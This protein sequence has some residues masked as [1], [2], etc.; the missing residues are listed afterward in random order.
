MIKSLRN[1][2]KWFSLDRMFHFHK[3]YGGLKSCTNTKIF[4]IGLVSIY[5]QT[6]LV[7]VNQG[8]LAW[9]FRQFWLELVVKINEDNNTTYGKWSC[10]KFLLWVKV[11]ASCDSAITMFFVKLHTFTCKNAE[12]VYTVDDIHLLEKWIKQN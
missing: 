4:K 2:L 8:V 9:S 11:S 1:I 7:E 6:P 12:R 10:N 5:S 3:K